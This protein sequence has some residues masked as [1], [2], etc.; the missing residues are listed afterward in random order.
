MSAVTQ[1]PPPTKW[2]LAY[3]LLGLR[4][5]AE[6][7]AWVAEDVSRAAFLN[8]RMA[9]AAL[10]GSAVAG[11]FLLAVTTVYQR[12]GTVTLYRIGAAVLF[13]AIVPSRNTFVRRALR[14]QQIDRHGRAARPRGLGLLTP[15][16]AVV[17]VGAVAI[18]AT[19]ASA[20][21]GYGLRPT[22]IEAAPCLKPDAVL[23]ARLK[24]GFKKPN[25]EFV[26]PQ[27]VKYAGGVV[28]VT[29]FKTP[30]E[31]KTLFTAFVVDHGTVYELHSPAREQEQPTTFPAPSKPDRTSVQAISRAAVCL[32]QAAPR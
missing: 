24:A 5:P 1:P 15:K 16:E 23:S 22:G 29:L 11:L 8:W 31:D 10:W 17:G 19:G 9:R 2:R 27:M 26:L 30:G 18:F 6:Y 25:V 4:L 20:V 12:L 3:R 21:F 28:V 13:V 32:Q 7:R 14:W